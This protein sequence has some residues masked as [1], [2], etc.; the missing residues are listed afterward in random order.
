[1]ARSSQFILSL[2]W[3]V[4]LQ[5][6]CDGENKTCSANVAYGYH[7]KCA[8]YC[9]LCGPDEGDLVLVE[10]GNSGN[11]NVELDGTKFGGGCRDGPIVGRL[12]S[13]CLLA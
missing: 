7:L 1:M 3:P 6:V 2:P 9:Y 8:N 13:T 11:F 12:P 5:G 4:C 10:S